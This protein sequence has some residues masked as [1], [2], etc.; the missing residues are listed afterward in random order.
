MKFID[1]NVGILFP[2]TVEF[3]FE[4]AGDILTQELMDAFNNA[5]KGLFRL[6]IGL[7][8]FNPKTLEA[9][10]RK[11]NVEKLKENIKKLLSPNNVHIHIDLIAGLPYEDFDSFAESFNTAF[12]LKP[13]VLQLGFLKLLHGSPMKEN[14][15]GIF[16][17]IP[18]YQV[19]ESPWLS[20]QEL[21]KLSCAEEA[22]EKLY[23]SGR[24]TDLLQNCHKYF[25]SPF[26]MFLKFGLE[27]NWLAGESLDDFTEKTFNFFAKYVDKVYLRDIMV[28]ERLSTN[29]SGKL[30]K[31]L[32]RDTMGKYLLMLDKIPYLAREKSVKR[33]VAFLQSSRELIWV[34][35]KKENFIDGRY[36]VNRICID[37]LNFKNVEVSKM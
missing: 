22:L 7:Q 2:N 16:S 1:E 33:A 10:N 34:D 6:E 19:Q 15:M 24:F 4:I 37:D 20:P 3:H 5:H 13:H 17:E 28:V 26:H 21:E 32:W 27:S 30:P 8:S 35:Y 31:I 12:A 14:P 36:I 23:N 29:S 11:T 9:V 18:P 25:Q